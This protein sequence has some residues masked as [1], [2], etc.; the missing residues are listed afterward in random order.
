VGIQYLQDLS[1]LLLRTRAELASVSLLLG[2]LCSEIRELCNSLRLLKYGL[3]A[4]SQ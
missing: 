2:K 1:L 3:R 4:L